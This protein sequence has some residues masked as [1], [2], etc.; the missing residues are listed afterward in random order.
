[1][2]SCATVI[3][4][5][6]ANAAMVAT[7]TRRTRSD[8]DNR[9]TVRSQRYRRR[10]TSICAQRLGGVTFSLRAAPRTKRP[11]REHLGLSEG[12]RPTGTEAGWCAR[13]DEL[14]VEIAG[15]TG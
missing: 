11:G 7:L 2:L 9:G 8:T 1:M 3:S 13:P 4:V 12:I 6:L 15:P 14:Q 5:E 10:S